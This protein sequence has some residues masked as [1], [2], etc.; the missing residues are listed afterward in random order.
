MKQILIYT[1]KEAEQELS[2]LK[3]CE[4]RIEQDVQVYTTTT[5][6]D[7]CPH[8]LSPFGNYTNGSSE[9]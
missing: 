1:I 2:K 8:I 9:I 7:N 4:V 3:C 5:T 6:E